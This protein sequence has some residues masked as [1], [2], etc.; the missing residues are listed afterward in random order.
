MNRKN[1]ETRNAPD[2]MQALEDNFT[3]HAIAAM[4]SFL[5]TAVSTIGTNA[6]EVDSQIEWFT[7]ELMTILGGPPAWAKLCEEIG[8]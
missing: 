4:A 3:P 5:N 6:P 7:H 1:H 8:L 2:L